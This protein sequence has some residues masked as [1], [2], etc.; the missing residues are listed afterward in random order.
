ML[1]LALL[2]WNQARKVELRQNEPEKA[3]APEDERRFGL[4]DWLE[5]A[6]IGC[7]P[8]R[9][10]PIPTLDRRF[11]PF[12]LMRPCTSIQDPKW[13][14]LKAHALLSVGNVLE[15]ALGTKQANVI[16]VNGCIK[17]AFLLL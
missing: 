4:A 2:A 3:S 8:Q 12:S 13:S 17:L 1:T 6:A 11:R 16:S 14:Y 9:Q 7:P 5:R 15:V 10:N